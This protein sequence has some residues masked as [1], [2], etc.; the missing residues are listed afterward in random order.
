MRHYLQKQVYE[1][2]QKE[3]ADVTP[4]T[5]DGQRME[6]V[7]PAKK[8]KKNRLWSMHCKKIQLK[9]E[10]GANHACN[11]TPCDH[12]GPCDSSCSCIQATNYCEKYCNCNNECKAILCIFTVIFLLISFA[13]F[14]LRCK[15]FSWLPMQGSM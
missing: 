8:K 13:V 11:Y 4:T 12:D 14:C 3:A 5:E 7:P 10:S 9:Q 15:S 6:N 1:F 2:A